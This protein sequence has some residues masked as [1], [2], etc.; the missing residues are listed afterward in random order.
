MQG[1]SRLNMEKCLTE[2]GISALKPTWRLK[3]EHPQ[4]LA[5]TAVSGLSNDELQFGGTSET[6]AYLHR[7][8]CCWWLSD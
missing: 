2:S 3:P 1:E 5:V 4:N 6:E 7:K 8:H